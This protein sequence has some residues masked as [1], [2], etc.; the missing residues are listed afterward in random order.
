LKIFK[1]LLVIKKNLA[2]LICIVVFLAGSCI[3]RQDI[4]G[5]YV[6]R[7]SVSNESSKIGKETACEMIG[8][9][10]FRDGHCYYNYNFLGGVMARA[11]FEID[12]DVIY[13]KNKTSMD[14][15]NGIE[16]LNDSTVSYYDCLFYKIK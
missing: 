5:K 1:Y 10:E 2:L 4:T 14:N 16:I 13:L 6:H 12:S 7:K 9:F 3:R 8:S 15:I 11:D